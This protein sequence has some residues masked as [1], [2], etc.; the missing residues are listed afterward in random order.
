MPV[1]HI[2]LVAIALLYAYDEMNLHSLVVILFP[3]TP[4]ITF[5]E[6]MKCYCFAYTCMCMGWV[7]RT[8]SVC[9]DTSRS[10]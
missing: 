1:R 10:W 6:S 4:M 3:Y 7:D 8:L 9:G 2:L 5:D